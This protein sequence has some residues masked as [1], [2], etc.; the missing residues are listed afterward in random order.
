MNT[1]IALPA[2]QNAVEFGETLP[3][4]PRAVAGRTGSFTN[5]S[6]LMLRDIEQRQDG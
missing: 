5:V 1:S 6:A 3:K 4:N 2:H